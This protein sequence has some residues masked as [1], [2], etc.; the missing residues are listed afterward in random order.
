MMV[1]TNVGDDAVVLTV[2][3]LNSCVKRCVSVCLVFV[4]SV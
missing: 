3:K 2:F 4:Y 1:V